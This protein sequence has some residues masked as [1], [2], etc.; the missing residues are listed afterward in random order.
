MISFH[1]ERIW[2]VVKISKEIC[3]NG[4]PYFHELVGDNST[5]NDK[6][7]FW[8]N[9]NVNGITRGIGSF[10]I[11]SQNTEVHSYR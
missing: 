8:K 10:K 3:K 7:C 4:L 9:L 1:H 6:E 11:P 2:N 5:E